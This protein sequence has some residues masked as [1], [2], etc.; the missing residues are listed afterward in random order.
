MALLKHLSR[1]QILLMG[2][3]MIAVVSAFLFG[4]LLR[5][6]G[7]VSGVHWAI[8]YRTWIPMVLITLVI[9]FLFNLYRQLWNYASVHEL[10]TIVKAVTIS[11]ISIWG[12]ATFLQLEFYPRSIIIMAWFLLIA[13]VG[14]SRFLLRYYHMSKKQV[15]YVHRDRSL[16]LFHPT[17]KHKKDKTEDRRVLII[18][19][20]D[21]GR[22]V[23]EDMKRNQDYRFRVVG[24]IDDDKNKIGQVLQGV[25][26]LGTT[27]EIGRLVNE[28]KIDMIVIA[29]PSSSGENVR[30][31]V[32]ICE[33][34]KVEIKILPGV[35]EI[36]N[37]TI[38]INQ[39]REVKLEDL[40]RRDPVDLDLKSISDYIKDKVVLVTG[41]GGSIGSELCRQLLW[42]KPK[43][44]IVY[45]SNE[46]NVYSLQQ[47][48]KGKFPQKRLSLV[49][50]D[51]RDTT[52]LDWVFSTY[53]PDVVFHAA[54]Y[55]HVPLMEYN[56][57][58][59]VMTNVFGTRNVALAAHRFAIDRFI[60]ISTDKAVNPTNIMGATKRVAEKMIESLNRTSTTRYVAVRFGNVMGSRGSVIPLFQEQIKN[61]GPL[62]VTH[63]DITRFFMTIPEA[64]QLVLQAAAFGKGGEVFVLDMGEPI[65]IIELARQL[66]R[67]CGLEPEK[68]IMIKII[69]LREGEKLYEEPLTSLQEIEK[70]SHEKIFVARLES[71]DLEKLE[72]R[73]VTLKQAVYSANAQDQ[74][75]LV[76]K[77]LVDSY[78]PESSPVSACYQ[79]FMEEVVKD[80]Q[81]V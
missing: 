46:Y 33:N 65:K 23:L 8:F 2:F 62:E 55:K 37:G 22:M 26:I 67:L 68:D 63:K 16:S 71:V 35:S 3:D 36:I 43:K 57:V 39:I 9:F 10:M 11:I 48:F 12:G 44:L 77:E 19:A 76:L 61:G 21:A 31:I 6:E 45:D 42:F 69:G 78:D 13:F 58:E 51:V 5:F 25:S 66:I 14:G 4:L 15:K 30:R 18:G 34:T 47:E 20:G 64:S 24:F 49:V 59:A 29:I 41:G 50:G 79:Q 7:Q 52:R 1:G 72:S 27:E 80:D 32:S 60:L 70:T 40:L 56:A 17:M 73:L 28:L 54:A 75:R 74:I 38:S 81:M 53:E